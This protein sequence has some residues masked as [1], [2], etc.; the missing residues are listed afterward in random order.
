EILIKIGLVDHENKLDHREWEIIWKQMNHLTLEEPAVGA[1]STG[2]VAVAKKLHGEILGIVFLEVVC[3]SDLPAARNVTKL[4]FDMDPFVVASFSRNTFRTKVISHKLNPV[5]NEKFNFPV[6]KNET[7]YSIKFVVYDWDKFSGNDLV[8]SQSLPI[9]QLLEKTEAHEGFVEEELPLVLHIQ[10]KSGEE[11]NPK[12]TIKSKFLPYEKLRFQFWKSLAKFYDS[13]DNGKLDYIEVETMLSSLGSSL[14]SETLS[15][16]FTRFGKAP[17]K[18]G[19]EFEELISCLEERL[20]I[21]QKSAT[22]D[23]EE[24][25]NEHIIYIKECP[26][27]HKPGLSEYTETDIITHVAICASDDL[28]KVDSFVTGDF[29]TE[30]QAQ[31]KWVTKIITKIG[32]GGYQIGGDSANIIVQDRKTGQLVEEKM[33]AY[34]RLG[35]RLL[36]RAKGSHIDSKRVQNLLRSLSIKQGKKFDKSSSAKDIVPFIKFHD[37][38]TKEILD[39]LESFKT[40]NEFF[41]RKLKPGARPCDSPDDPHVLVSP[42]DCRMMAFS[43][44][45]NATKLWIKGQNFTIDKLLNDASAAKEFEGGSLGDL[46][47]SFP[48][49]GEYYTVNPMAIRSELDVY[50]ENKRIVS[51]I[52]SL[53][54]GKVAYVAIGAMMVGSIVLTSVPSTHVKRTDEHGGSTVVLLF[55]RGRML[56]DEDI[57]ENSGT[58]METLFLSLYDREINI[59]SRFINNH[60]LS[61]D[62]ILQI[63][64]VNSV[65]ARTHAA[66]RIARTY[67]LQEDKMIGYWNGMKKKSQKL[68]CNLR[69]KSTNK[70]FVPPALSNKVYCGYRSCDM[71]I[72]VRVV[73]SA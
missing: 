49:P 9:K 14:T 42:A 22:E 53:Q 55:Q 72:L 64:V 35:I 68:R 16:F 32:F 33:A 28:G 7:K 15:S 41:Y 69:S 3:A 46:S 73:G 38:D 29:V 51:Y 20:K 50:G 21:S 66:L 58:C 43:T 59:W 63:Y 1:A 48:V 4:G 57:L 8:A 47:R 26:I 71:R 19:L 60:V 36:Y 56:W 27:C 44:F 12:L 37:L 2:D 45:D 13:D 62:Y 6:K 61:K 5:W 65:D 23:G 39:P 24:A 10:G 17:H 40:F 67:Y 11:Y 52:Q 34:V 30:S 31:R 70:V 25:D 54:F 18:D